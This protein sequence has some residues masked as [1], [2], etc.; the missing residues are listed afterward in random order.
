[1]PFECGVLDG[2]SSIMRPKEPPAGSGEAGEVV[3]EADRSSP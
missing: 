3:R 1:V 2:H